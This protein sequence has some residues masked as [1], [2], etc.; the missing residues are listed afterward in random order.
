VFDWMTSTD[1]LGSVDIEAYDQLIYLFKSE[2]DRYYR[3]GQRAID[4]LT[5]IFRAWNIPIGKI[6]GPNVVLA[7]QVF[8]QMTVAEMINSIL[9]Q[10]KDKE[11]ASLSYVVKREG[12]YQKSHV[13]SRCLRVC[14]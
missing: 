13:Q 4:V 12:L 10:G 2:D 3:S 7:K 6:E 11:Q 8:R 5:D 14:I 9:K 1:P